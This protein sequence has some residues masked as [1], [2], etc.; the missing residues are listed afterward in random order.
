MDL[1]YCLNIGWNGVLIMVKETT[2]WNHNGKHQDVAERMNPLVPRQGECTEGS[3]LELFRVASNAYY[4]LYNNG[5][6]NAEVRLPSL[7]DEIGGL[8]EKGV[9]TQASEAVQS[10]IEEI[11][12]FHNEYMDAEATAGWVGDEDDEDEYWEED[13]PDS[14]CLHEPFEVFMDFVLE[15]CRDCDDVEAPFSGVLK[16]A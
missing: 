13:Y 9:I 15:L 11:I 2:Y 10:A 4:D 5:M 8:R 14:G 1:V 3:L 7:I 12:T 16:A 6:G